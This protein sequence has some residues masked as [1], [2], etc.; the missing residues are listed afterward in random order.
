MTAEPAPSTVPAPS[1]IPAQVP[2]SEPA[3]GIP[4]VSG[5]IGSSE[6]EEMALVKSN[7]NLRLLF[8]V[9]GSG[10]YLADIKVR[11]SETAG[12]TLLT[13][14]SKGPWFYVKLVPGRY[15]LTLDKAG[16][17]QTR[18]VTVPANGAIQEAFYWAP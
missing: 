12:A 4:Y 14:V 18:E 5:G 16:Q 9:Q 13:A 10:A 3:V 2:P 7:Y 11:V 17:I 15:L 1:T 8:A 6:R